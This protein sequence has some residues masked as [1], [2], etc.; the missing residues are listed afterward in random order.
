MQSLNLM[1]SS[2]CSMRGMG[3][4]AMRWWTEVNNSPRVW[5]VRVRALD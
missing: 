2:R 3:E 4:W 5:T 1:T